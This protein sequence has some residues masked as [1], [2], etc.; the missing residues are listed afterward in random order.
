MPLQVRDLHPLIETDM[1]AGI[2][3]GIAQRDVPQGGV[4]LIESAYRIEGI[5]A[6][7]AAAGP[8][9]YGALAAALMGV[10]V[11]EVVKLAEKTGGRRFFGVRTED[12]GPP[13]FIQ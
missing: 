12:R 9:G 10:M 3:K 7:R 4:A 6:H 1:K 2:R 8:E 13:T 5:P 11:Q